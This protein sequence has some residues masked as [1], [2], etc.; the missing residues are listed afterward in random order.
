MPEAGTRFDA[1]SFWFVMVCEVV[2]KGSSLWHFEERKVMVDRKSFEFGV[3]ALVTHLSQL[4]TASTFV[5]SVMSVPQNTADRIE[6]I[7]AHNQYIRDE[8]VEVHWVCR[9][10]YS[11]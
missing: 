9:L 7:V 3:P 10:H 1:W 5:V 6:Q 11:T 2:Q 4:L 8:I